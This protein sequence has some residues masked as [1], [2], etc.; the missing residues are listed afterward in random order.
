VIGDVASVG[1]S[2][3]HGNSKGSIRGKG[4]PARATRWNLPVLLLVLEVHVGSDLLDDFVRCSGA[5]KLAQ[6]IQ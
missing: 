6:G 3:Q 2:R 4:F 5:A 1:D